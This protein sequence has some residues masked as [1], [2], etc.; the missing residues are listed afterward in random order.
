MRVQLAQ[1]AVVTLDASG[2]GTAK[3]GPLSARE[4]WY[5][6]NVHVSVAT[7]TNEATCSIYVGTSVIAAN[8]RDGTF[9]GSSGDAT[10]RVSADVVRSGA[11]VWAVWSGGDPGAVATL[12]VTGERE[13]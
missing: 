9:S 3:I 5:P 2:D 10:D 12:T 13:I 11:S 1:N 7:N 8:F 6:A 4:T